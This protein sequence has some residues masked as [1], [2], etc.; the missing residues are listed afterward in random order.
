MA[1]RRLVTR[2]SIDSERYLPSSCRYAHKVSQPNHDSTGTGIRSSRGATSGCRCAC[3]T[4]GADCHSG[5]LQHRESALGRQPNVLWN[6][7]EAHLSIPETEVV[8]APQIA[9]R[10]IVEQ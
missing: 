8:H 3:R 1:T 5:L 6:L 2:S 4:A 9:R 7:E 10:A